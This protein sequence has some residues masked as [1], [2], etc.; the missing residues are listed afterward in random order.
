M[1]PEIDIRQLTL[2][3]PGC[4]TARARFDTGVRCAVCGVLSGSRRG[5]RCALPSDQGALGRPDAIKLAGGGMRSSGSAAVMRYLTTSQCSPTR[6]SIITGRYPHNTA[7][8][9]LHQPLPAGQI[10]FPQILKDS[11]YHPATRAGGARSCPGRSGQQ[12]APPR[13]M[14]ARSPTSAQT[15]APPNSLEWWRG[16][17]RWPCRCRCRPLK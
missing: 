4:D 1:V 12:A 3:R 6:C 8:P 16:N 7:A 9:E 10:M 17:S 15:S 2:S 5:A 13:T 14:A 11:E